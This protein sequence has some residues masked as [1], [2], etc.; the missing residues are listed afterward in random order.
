MKFKFIEKI[1][2]SKWQDIV[3]SIASFIFI[4]SLVPQ[5]IMQFNTGIVGITFQTSI[6][7]SIGLFMIVISMFSLKLYFS[8]ITNLINMFL[9][10][11][12][13]LQKIWMN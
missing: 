3:L 13:V 6:L 11:I 2:K 5:I 9:W 12:I 7:T 4:Y 8:T 10:I 1:K